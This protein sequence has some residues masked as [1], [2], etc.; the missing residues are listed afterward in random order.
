MDLVN[1]IYNLKK[2][3][4]VEQLRN[5]LNHFYKNERSIEVKVCFEIRSLSFN[6]YLH[7]ILN[8]FALEYGESLRFVKKEIFKKIINPDIFIVQTDVENEF[9]LRSTS[10]LTS[11]ELYVCVERFKNFCAKE[12]NCWFPEFEDN[13]AIAQMQSYVEQNLRWL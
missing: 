7:V 6:A 12:L 8:V 10:E 5:D 13:E 2:N 1:M 9:K 3:N 4:D 11:Y